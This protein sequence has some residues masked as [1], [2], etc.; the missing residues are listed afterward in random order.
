[1]PTELAESQVDFLWGKYEAAREVLD[2]VDLSI[3]E[4]NSI[5]SSVEDSFDKIEENRNL[6]E[7]AYDQEPYAEATQELYEEYL[8]AID[9]VASE[10]QVLE[11]ELVYLDLHQY[12]HNSTMSNR[13][14]HASS[15][16]SELENVFGIDVTVL[17]VIWDGFA[18]DPLDENIPATGQLSQIYVLILPRTQ[19]EPEFYAPIIAH[20]LAHAILDRQQALKTEFHN[21][22]R[23]VQSR[24]RQAIDN[25]THFARSWRA[26]FEELFCDTCGVLTFGPAYLSS[27]IRH[28]HHSNP[29]YIEK[30]ID[31]DLHPPPALR[32]DLVKDLGDEFFPDLMDS[33]H[34]DRIAFER[35]L[36]ALE[37]SRPRIY[38]TYDYDE[39]RTFV[40]QE[41]PNEVNHDLEALVEDISAGV[42]PND[43]SNRTHRLATNE[44]WLET[45]PP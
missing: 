18:V 25:E 42:N 45:Y 26:W 24:T 6:Y 11:F 23:D 32:F 9:V 1:M 39:L 5:L 3:P 44:Y 33:I 27:L 30:D 20:E 7:R 43:S 28:L 4:T 21:V 31:R 12:Q 17:P 14:N 16:S 2:T 35:H 13:L 41:V 36:D 10:L 8:A 40:T 15:L 29:Y 19:S 34:D 37:H 22:V 38:D